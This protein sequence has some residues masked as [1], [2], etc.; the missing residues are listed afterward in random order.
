MNNTHRLISAAPCDVST[1]RAC[2]VESA[3]CSSSSVSCNAF[4]LV[5]SLLDILSQTCLRLRNSESTFSI[6][7]GGILSSLS[8]LTV[9]ACIGVDPAMVCM[10]AKYKVRGRV[11]I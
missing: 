7:D 8:T 4:N 9:S 5:K 3:L 1:V 11:K 10:G 6:S 2:Y